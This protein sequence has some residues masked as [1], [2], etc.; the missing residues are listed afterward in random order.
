MFD[1]FRNHTRLA[2][3]FM[4]LLI[5]PS[6][7]FFGVEGYRKL[8]DGSSSAVAK[9]D[10]RNISRAEW[11]S[12]HQ[13]FV[14]NARAQMKGGDTAVLDT[15]ERRHDTLEGLVRSRVLLAA[16]TDLH[17]A[18]NDSRLQ[19]LFASD[20]QFAQ[21]RNA[22]GSVNREMLAMQGMNS[23]IFVQRLRQDLA[24]QQVLDG[25]ARSAVAPAAVVGAAVDPLFQ[26]REIQYQRF[27][28]GAYLDKV[29]PSD[30][31]LEAFYK[32][33]TEDF[34]A[35]EQAQIEYVMLDLQAVAD[36][37]APSDAEVRKYYDD[38]LARFAA[39]EERKASHILINADKAQPAAARQAAK[40]KAEALLAEARK[41][42]AGFAE[43][44]RKNSQDEGS[45][46]QGGDLGFFG[47]G[48]MVKP[49]EDAAFALKQGELAGPVETDYGYHVILLTG[50]KGNNFDEIKA[51]VAAELKK[52]TAQRRWP[53]LAEQFTNTAYEQSDSLQPVLDKLKLKKL[54]ATVQRKAAPGA[55]GPLASAKLLDAVFSQ[56]AVANKRNTDAVEVGPNQLVSA[57]V[58]Q[59]T[60][61]RVLPMADVSDKVRQRLV[62]QQALEL[63]R[64]DGQTRLL[65]LQQPGAAVAADKQLASAVVSRMQPQGVPRAVLEAALRA[66]PAKLPQVLGVDVPEGGFVVLR[67][68]AVLP[69]EAMPGGDEQLRQ[70]YAQAWAAAESEAYVSA[71]KLRYKATISPD[72]DVAVVP[73]SGAA[74]SK[75]G[76]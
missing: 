15:P 45:A 72:A 27:D 40:A 53:E 8:S 37:S 2:L 50:V 48:S 66:D 42:P 70:Q 54:T 19:R 32:S 18:P 1:F 9:V 23:D 60:A 58:L 36:A 47:R 21:L 11:D 10:G 71:L 31:E 74:A 20:P 38:N 16:A 63:A 59:H 69:R 52:N 12:A 56:E 4:L 26:R 13:R 67:V 57:R 75:P 68:A 64:K 44:A 35:P 7:V 65:A 51:D 22:D 62:A 43:L 39:K 25:V 76:R 49:F 6:F 29:K 24:V 55:A 5:I 46:V 28:A 73:V 3:G 30:A 33:H 61:A 34:K 14:Q 17:L 41:N